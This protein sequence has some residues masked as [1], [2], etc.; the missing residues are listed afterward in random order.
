M[1]AINSRILRIYF[2]L[3]FCLITNN[4]YAQTPEELANLSINELLSLSLDEL[5]SFNLGDQGDATGQDLQRSRWQVSYRYRRAVFEGYRD[6]TSDIP[7]SQVL[8]DG[9]PANRTSKNFPIVP[10]KITQEAHIF[11]VGYQLDDRSA[12]N[13]IVPYILQTTDH[14]S[15]VPGFSSFTISSEGIGDVVL[16]YRRDVWQRDNHLIIAR[17]GISLPTGSIDEEGDTPRAPGDQQ[18]PYTM[19]LGS[20]TFD[21]PVGINYIGQKD[22]WSW[23]TGVNAKFRLGRNSR[24][25]RLGHTASVS[26]WSGR[27]ISSWLKPTVQID[28]KYTDRIHGMDDEITVPGAFPFPASITNPDLFGGHKISTLFG[29]EVGPPS[30][31]FS[32]HSLGFGYSMPIYQN[33]N[34][35]QVKEDDQISVNWNWH[36]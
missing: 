19:Q 25:Y 31:L 16:S 15:I 17:A 34:G 33:L 3:I 23:G 6:G 10:T 22:K 11:N 7:L 18:L 14:V 35:P 28:Y 26:V 29:I 5:M 21:I 13:V 24:D 20:G 12:I 36:F 8:F 32:N 30:G 27:Q 2:L 9:N 1:K 4:L